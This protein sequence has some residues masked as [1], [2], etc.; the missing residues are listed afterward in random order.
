M[1]LLPSRLAGPKDYYNNRRYQEP[2]I[3]GPFRTYIL[4]GGRN[5]ETT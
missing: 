3:N 5:I 4:E 1:V 2:F